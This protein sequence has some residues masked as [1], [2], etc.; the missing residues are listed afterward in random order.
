MKANDLAT[1][2]FILKEL[3]DGTRDPFL[4]AIMDLAMIATTAKQEDAMTDPDQ[5]DPDDQ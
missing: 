4:R 1:I 5:P 3:R 2:W